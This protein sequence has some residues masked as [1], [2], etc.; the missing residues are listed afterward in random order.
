MKNLGMHDA[1]S[2]AD[3]LKFLIKTSANPKHSHLQ[4]IVRISNSD[5]GS[6]VTR[7]PTVQSAAERNET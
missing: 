3:F 6:F 1:D 2:R 7:P 4:P 5:D